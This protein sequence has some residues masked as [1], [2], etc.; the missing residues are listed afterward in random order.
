[1]RPALPLEPPTDSLQ[2]SEY[3]RCLA[4]RP[5]HSWTAKTP[6]ISG[7]GS[8]CSKRSARTRN[9]RAFV[10]ATAS[11]RSCPYASTPGSSGTSPI[12]LPSS[13]RSISTVKSFIRRSYN[14]RRRERYV[15]GTV[16]HGSVSA[17]TVTLPDTAG[18]C[19]T[20]GGFRHLPARRLAAN[21]VVKPPQNAREP[22]FGG[23]K[24]L[25]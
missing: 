4:P 13:S 11:S 16:G 19:R 8:P 7:I 14:G 5:I 18:Q 2:R 1:M 22:P 9:A 10:L 12:H 15:P 6:S 17:E 3:S 23:S 21:L 20:G 24:C 25:I